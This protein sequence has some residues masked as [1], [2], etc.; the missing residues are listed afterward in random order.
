MRFKQVHDT[1]E[2]ALA[3]FKDKNGQDADLSG[4]LVAGKPPFGWETADQLRNAWGKG[5]ALIQ[6]EVIGKTPKLGHTANIVID[7]QTG[8]NGKPRMPKGGPYLTPEQIQVIIDWIDGGC[9][10]DPAPGP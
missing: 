8:L 10:P 7:L 1:L 9:L 6:P 4:H 2:A 3:G 5:V